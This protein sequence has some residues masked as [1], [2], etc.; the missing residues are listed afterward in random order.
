MNNN[1]YLSTN[2]GI[3]RFYDGTVIAIEVRQ[4]SANGI[5]NWE[6]IF[7]PAPH[8][9]Q[10][11]GVTQLPGHLYTR[12]KHTGD[13][14]FQLPYR[15]IPQD[16]QM[17]A[18][19]YNL[20]YKLEDDTEWT[21]LYDLSILKGEDGEDGERGPQGEG[22]NIDEVGYYKL[23][24]DCS[25]GLVSSCTSC[26]NTGSSNVPYLF[27]SIGDGLIELDSTII[28]AGNV[29][30]GLVVY[31]HF[32]HDLVTWTAISSANA[33]QEVRYL[34]TDGTGAVYTDM[35]DE[36]YYSTRGKVYVCADGKW[37][38]FSDLTAPSYQIAETVGSTNIGYLDNFILTG[39]AGYLSGTIGLNS[40]KLEIIEETI[41][42][43]A[44]VQ[45]TFGD[46]IEI[47]V[48]QA[49][50]RIASTDFSGFG[51]DT[52]TSTADSLVDIQVDISTLI[53]DG[54]SSATGVSVDGET[55]NQA[56]VNVTDLLNN[57]SFIIAGANP[58]PDG[59][60]DLFV[61]IGD[62][63]EGD[64]G[65]PQAIK[66]KADELSLEVNASDLHIKTYAAG[67]DG[68]LA[69]YLNP[70][71]ANTNAGLL[72]NNSTG[73]E[74]VPDSVNGSLGF[75]G[76]GE[77]EVPVN[78]IQGIHIADNICSNNHGLEVNTDA[79]RV[80][81]DGTSIGFNGSGE[82]EFT[83]DI[84]SV[85]TASTD[86]VIKSITTN[87]NGVSGNT[88][89]DDVIF[90]VN[91]GT[92]ITANIVADTPSD[93]ITLDMQFDTAWGDARYALAGSVGTTWGSITG[94]ITNQADLV[95]YIGGLNHVVIDTLYG[96]ATIKS[97][98]LWL[99]S[100][101]GTEYRLIVDDNGN[102]D[103]SLV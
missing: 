77:L 25:S 43:T 24:R 63:L 86:V 34:A 97:T 31:S 98:G 90:R 50:P 41:D 20:E 29:T 57:D 99:R 72:V 74:I 8:V 48:A 73:I 59:Y 45:T 11:D 69:S 21:F 49:K 95:A 33:G 40:G 92:G 91:D 28:A 1:S 26:N 32:S 5:D 4:Y 85:I 23:R 84:S 78:A 76:T 79:L 14:D 6:P 67:N 65:A 12:V 38:L 22:I 83:G 96:N 46:G 53:L 10:L 2:N 13:V 16:I 44:L 68:I 18:D 55:H 100:P 87:D 27:L 39:A 54:L 36:D 81:V 103:T 17:Q 88:V 47:N 80:K 66:V 51:L 93:T 3:I 37:T 58:V 62:G 64:G 35:R 7:N 70:N 82:L 60:N 15:I 61:N 56:Y 30:V 71:V 94:I 9:S 102:L 75:S 19:G 101:G 52:Y 89:R 42:E